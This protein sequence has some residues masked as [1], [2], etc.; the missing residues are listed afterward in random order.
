MRGFATDEYQNRLARAQQMMAASG[1]DAL[2]LTTETDVRYFTGFFNPLLG[3]P[4][5]ALVCDY[6]AIR[7]AHCGNPVY[8]GGADGQDMDSRYPHLVSP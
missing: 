6:P 4:D 5:P 8:R 3:K 1:L 7:K 2:F